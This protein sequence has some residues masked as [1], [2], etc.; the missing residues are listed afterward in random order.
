MEIDKKWENQENKQCARDTQQTK[1]PNDRP[2]NKKHISV[3]RNKKLAS[4]RRHRAQHYYP[5]VRFHILLCFFFLFILLFLA[6]SQFSV[7]VFAV[8][9][10]N[11]FS[12]TFVSYSLSALDVL[13]HCVFRAYTEASCLLMTKAD[14]RGNFHTSSSSP[15]LLTMKGRFGIVGP[16]QCEQLQQKLLASLCLFKNKL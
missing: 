11:I 16:S 3:A 1:A 6:F 2:T 5:V 4:S 10:K 7:F 12:R 8:R 9:G 14:R 13:V 15:M